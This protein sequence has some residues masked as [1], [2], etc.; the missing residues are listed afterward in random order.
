MFQYFDHKFLLEYRIE[1]KPGIIK[2]TKKDT[3]HCE[4]QILKFGHL[5]CQNRPTR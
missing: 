3:D 5:I 1:V 2:L 4:I